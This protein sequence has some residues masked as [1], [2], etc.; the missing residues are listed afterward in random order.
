MEMI[1]LGRSTPARRAYEVGLVNQVV[2]NG[3]HV[4]VARAMGEEDDAA[5]QCLPVEP[6]PPAPRA[7]SSKLSTTFRS[8]RTT[9]S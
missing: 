4:R 8:T 9:F 3:E 2:P 1:Y 5:H 7:L 6:K